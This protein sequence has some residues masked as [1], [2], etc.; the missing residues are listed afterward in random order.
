[1]SDEALVGGVRSAIVVAPLDEDLDAAVPD[2]GRELS[3]LES[4]L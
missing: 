4:S 1:V 3:V 2:R